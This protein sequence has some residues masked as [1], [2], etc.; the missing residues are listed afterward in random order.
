[1]ALVEPRSH[2]GDPRGSRRLHSHFP[3]LSHLYT[4][5]KANRKPATLLKAPGAPSASKRHPPPPLWSMPSHAAQNTRV[6]PLLEAFHL[7]SPGLEH[8]L[9]NWPHSFSPFRASSPLWSTAL[10]LHPPCPS[11]CRRHSPHQDHATC[12]CASVSP[13]L[14]CMFLESCDLVGLTPAVCPQPPTWHMAMSESA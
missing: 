2:L 9:P 5:L 8:R 11:P 12:S 14:G 3:H 7:L 1:M 13:P 6:P 4:A 10:H